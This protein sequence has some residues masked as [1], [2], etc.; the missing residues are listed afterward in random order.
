MRLIDA[1]ALNERVNESQRDNP[2][3]DPKTWVSH[4]NEHGHFL[5]MII[6]APTIDAEPVRH[7]R[8]EVNIR[9]CYKAYPPYESKRGYKCSLCGRGTRS[10]KE[11]Y[12][13]CGAKMDLEEEHD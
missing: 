9:M 7:G 11:P 4:T 2:H 5:D 6:E 13:H 3:K 10:K 12:C 1:D 8:W